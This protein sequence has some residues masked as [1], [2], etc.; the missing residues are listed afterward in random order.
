MT[1]SHETEPQD[2]VIG[3]YGWDDTP[4]P[5]RTMMR[6]RDMLA[7]QP[8]PTIPQQR[9]DITTL[10]SEDFEPRR[11]RWFQRGPKKQ[12]QIRLYLG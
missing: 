7:P 5:P 4:I 12:Y 2:V 9:E 1:T 10:I 3:T 11:R 8:E 6:V